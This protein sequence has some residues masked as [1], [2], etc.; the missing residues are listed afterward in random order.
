M[1]SCKHKNTIIYR[2]KQHCNVRRGQHWPARTCTMYMYV[3]QSENVYYKVQI[4]AA[5]LQNQK[6]KT[7][8]TDWLIPPFHQSNVQYEAWDWEFVQKRI[9]TNFKTL[10]HEFAIYGMKY[11]VRNDNCE[12][13]RGRGDSIRSV[14]PDLTLITWMNSW[15]EEWSIV[16]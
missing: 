15:L 13:E 1:R 4:Q 11:T 2:E 7:V 10:G 9:F 6:F 8:F 3:R 14:W 12:L 16:Q 5:N